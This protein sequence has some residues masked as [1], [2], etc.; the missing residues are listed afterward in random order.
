MLPPS[1]ELKEVGSKLEMNELGWG[2]FDD[3]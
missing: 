2:C 3:L 1:S